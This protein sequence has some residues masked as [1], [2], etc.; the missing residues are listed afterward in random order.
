MSGRPIATECEWCSEIARW[1]SNDG[2]DACDRHK[3]EQEGPGFE[4]ANW[5]PLDVPG[6]LTKAYEAHRQAGDGGGR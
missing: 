2:H 3:A 6:W 5:C 4:E 1:H